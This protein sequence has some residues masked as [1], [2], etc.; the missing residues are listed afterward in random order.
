M[1]EQDNARDKARHILEPQTNKRYLSGDANLD[2]EVS[3]EDIA[4]LNKTLGKKLNQD[5][6]RYETI[7]NYFENNLDRVNVNKDYIDGLKN[8]LYFLKRDASS[9]IGFKISGLLTKIDSW[10]GNTFIL[11]LKKSE[12]LGEQ[13]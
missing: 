12:E 6:A 8:P 10:M 1:T 4:N 13:N 11:A 7:V 5:L 9:A 3:F 2:G